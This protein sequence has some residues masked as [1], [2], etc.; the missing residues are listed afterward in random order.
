MGFIKRLDWFVLKAFLQ[1]LAA[2]FFICLFVFMMQ[3][4]WRYIDELIGKGLSTKVLAQFFWYMGLNFVPVALPPGILL[5]SLITFGN[6]GEKLELL[7]MKAAGI[8]LIRILEPLFF[9]VLLLCG[10]SFYFQNNVAP[11]ATKQLGALV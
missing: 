8:P 3:Y 9:L 5:A 7:A 1:L 2:T 6:M 11:E 10:A 4:T